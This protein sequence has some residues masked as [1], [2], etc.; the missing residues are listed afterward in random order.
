MSKIALED[1]F[2]DILSKAM[3]GLRISD[4]DLAQKS[5]VSAE[6][7]RA[8]CKGQLD[9]TSLPRLAGPLN[10]DSNA[11][12][13]SAMKTWYPYP[14]EMEG[15]RQ[16]NTS[17]H[18]GIKV[19]AFVLWDPA[20]KKAA[21]FDTGTDAFPILEFLEKNG[22]DA[23]GLFLTHTH[24][25]HLA[26][27]DTFARRLGIPVYASEREPADGAETF[28]PGTSF[29]AGALK[30]ETRLTW[31]HSKGGTTY[32]VT[33]LEEPVAVV[34]DALFAGSMGGGMISYADA[35]A[36]NRKEIFSLPDE[37]VICPGHGPVTTVKEEKRHNPFY[38]EYK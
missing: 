26:E 36:T 29:A 19:N 30:I 33:G 15:L 1:D 10:L 3:T 20:S 25:D 6:T 35:L 5:G 34:G 16:F 8:L 9:E 7:I 37:T 2:N 17:Y 13:R 12:L 21:I 32:V 14:V 22:L 28:V 18:S 4:R 11:L 31:G 24:P 23:V 27:K 38:P